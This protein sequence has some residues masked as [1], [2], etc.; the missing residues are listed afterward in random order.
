MGEMNMGILI[1]LNYLIFG[2]ILFILIHLFH[3]KFKIKK[4]DQLLLSFIYLILL[5]GIFIDWK[6]YIENIFMVFI[7][8]LISDIIYTSYLLEKDF[9]DN[10]DDKILYYSI[11][12]IGGFILNHKYF[13]KVKTIFPTG[14]DL[15]IIC[16]LLIIL[17]L[18][19]FVKG[20]KILKDFEEQ[21][22]ET[23]MMS[24]KNI[25]INYAKLKYEY[26]E[27]L[28][29]Y[30]KNMQ[31][32]LLSIMIYKNS[33]VPRFKRKI[34]NIKFKITGKKQAL[35][36]MQVETSKY[37]TDEESIEIAYKKLERLSGDKKKKNE[38]EIIMKY[39]GKE[40]EP[41][42]T[43]YNTIKKYEKK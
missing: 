22:E 29:S 8:A 6:E 15:R 14:D 26:L 34:Q 39:M 20:Y 28:N 43:I 19:R 24:D 32:V 36:V 9:F 17:Y 12:I 37:I 3:E 38:E 35:G 4:I 30:P 23:F 21:K 13:M 40:K 2:L 42:L 10:K 25:M 31:E 11:L 33:K 7:F 1:W 41:V 5:A 16:F 18:Y 27:E